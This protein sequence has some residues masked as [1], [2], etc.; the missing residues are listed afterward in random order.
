M[1]YTMLQKIGHMF[2]PLKGVYPSVEQAVNVFGVGD[3]GVVLSDVYL[4]F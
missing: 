2:Y 4:S 1:S 3:Q